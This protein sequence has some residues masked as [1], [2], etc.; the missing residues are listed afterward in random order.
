MMLARASVV[1]VLALSTAIVRTPPDDRGRPV[2]L[3]VHGRGLTGRDTAGLRAFWLAGLVA[4]AKSFSKQPLIDERDVRL[5]WYADVLQPSSAERCTY[6]DGDPRARRDAN[7]DPELKSFVS[8]IGNVLG[9]LTSFVS[10]N[11]SA[12]ELRSLSGDASFLSDSHTRC[13]AEHR[14]ADAIDRAEREGRPVIVVAHSLGSLVAYDYLTSRREQGAV[15]RVVSIGSPLGSSELRR[16]LIGGDS[17][18]SFGLPT[19]V[20]SWINVRSAADPLAMPLSFGKDLVT[21]TPTDEPDAHEITGYLRGA[22]TAKA[23]LEGWCAAF[24]S[25][26]PSA[27]ATIRD[28]R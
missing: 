26:A 1:V 18:E 25:A 9:A 6:A 21:S 4:G 2:I 14:L 27:C 20:K 28:E 10:D 17:T 7:S 15:Q 22:T 23:I 3:M 16:L 19:S 8:F 5:V 11:E 12:S 24:V 13:A